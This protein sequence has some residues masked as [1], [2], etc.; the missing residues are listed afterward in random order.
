MNLRQRRRTRRRPPFSAGGCVCGSIPSN[1]S[2]YRSIRITGR[3]MIV[4]AEAHN[5]PV[6]RE[7]DNGAHPAVSSA[8]GQSVMLRCAEAASPAIKRHARLTV[9]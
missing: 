4:A 1:E 9:R 3:M 5:A 7:F 8:A 2:G 6:V